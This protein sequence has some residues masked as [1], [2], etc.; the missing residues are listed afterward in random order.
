MKH[1]LTFCL[2]FAVCVTFAQSARP[3]SIY[4]MGEYNKP[5]FEW[6]I[7]NS[8]WGIGL[9]AETFFM[10]DKKFQ[11]TIDV[12]GNIFIEKAIVYQP[13]SSTEKS[14]DICTKEYDLVPAESSG[15]GLGV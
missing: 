10:I 5:I 15:T 9:G 6:G 4:I 8:P 13:S 2:T 3:I 14:S 7:R 11:P 1:L 12:S